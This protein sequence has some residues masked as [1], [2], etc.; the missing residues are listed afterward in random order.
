MTTGS[1]PRDALP[2]FVVDRALEK[3]IVALGVTLVEEDLYEYAVRISEHTR[4]DRR[5]LLGASPRATLSLIQV[6]KAAS[7]LDGRSYVTPDDLRHYAVSVLAHRLVLADEVEGEIR[8]SEE[9][10]ESAVQRVGY[11]K[12]I[13]ST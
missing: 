6:A 10:V 9:I 11:R 2:L 1:E 3:D 4:A 7:L 13:R 5:V 8:A 12:G